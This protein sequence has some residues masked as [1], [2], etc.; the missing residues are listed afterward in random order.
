MNQFE[1]MFCLNCYTFFRLSI[2]DS[3]QAIHRTGQV[4]IQISMAGG[5]KPRI[6]YKTFQLQKECGG[7]GLHCLLEYFYAAQ[8]RPLICLCA[9][10]Y[11]ARWNELEV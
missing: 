4:D 10:S 8:L 1:L 5:K 6:R 3:T 11:S 7:M 9:S 2:E